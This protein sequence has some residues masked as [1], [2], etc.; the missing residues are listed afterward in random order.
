MYI[1]IYIYHH[2]NYR[3]LTIGKFMAY[4]TAFFLPICPVLCLLL[5]FFA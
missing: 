3:S 1:Y 2:H 5:Y 4:F